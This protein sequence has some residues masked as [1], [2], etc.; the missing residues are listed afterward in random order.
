MLAWTEHA[1]EGSWFRAEDRVEADEDGVKLREST[2]GRCPPA[3]RLWWDSCPVPRL[4][5]PLT[6]QL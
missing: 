3:G 6:V 2:S 4:P 1:D 5:D